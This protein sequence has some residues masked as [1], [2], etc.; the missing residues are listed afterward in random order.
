MQQELFTPDEVP[1]TV[2]PGTRFAD[3][4]FDR[5]VDQAFTYAVG[6]LLA[7]RLGPGQRVRVPFGRGDKATVGYCV[8]V[9]D[10]S[11]R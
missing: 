6:P 7:D 11:L 10:H 1:I 8:R 5:P 4:V 3:V 9:S 2:P